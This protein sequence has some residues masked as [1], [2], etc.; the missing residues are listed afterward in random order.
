MEGSGDGAG[1]VSGHLL[2]FSSSHGGH[3]VVS[4]GPG[5]TGSVVLGDVGVGLV[6]EVLS[7]GELLDGSV[8]ETEVGDVLHEEVIGSDFSGL[9]SVEF[10]ALEDGGGETGGILNSVAR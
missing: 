1:N 8:G 2:L 3:E 7:E 4:S 6:E 10:V 9:S 5:L